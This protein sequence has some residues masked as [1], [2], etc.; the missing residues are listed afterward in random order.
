MHAGAALHAAS[1][2]ADGVNLIK[3]DDMKLR[4]I[5]F[6]RLLRLSILWER[7]GKD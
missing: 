7:A 3:N 4:S 6:G 2:L 1:L 5:P